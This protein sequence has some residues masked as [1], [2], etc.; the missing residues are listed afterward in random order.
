MVKNNRKS[1][2]H[3]AKIKYIVFIFTHLRETIKVSV[4][5]AST[6]CFI[7]LCF[8]TWRCTKCDAQILCVIFFQ[9]RDTSSADVAR[10]L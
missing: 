5:F 9:Y 4:Q 10:G 3:K 8:V 1:W 7:R 2:L 6:V